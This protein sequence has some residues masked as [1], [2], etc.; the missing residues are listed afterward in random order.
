MVEDKSF[1]DNSMK[2]IQNCYGASSNY[3][4]KNVHRL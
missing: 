4:R 3:Y 1:I 2:M